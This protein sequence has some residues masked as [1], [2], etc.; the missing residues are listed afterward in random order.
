MKILQ[1]CKKFPYPLKDGETIAVTYLSKALYELGCEITLLCMNTSKHHTDVANI[2]DNYNHYKD[3]HFVDIDNSIT[4]FGAFTNLFRKESYHVSRFIS[5]EFKT[6]IIDILSKEE[7]DVIQLETLYLAPYVDLIREHTNA[8]ITMRAHNVEHEI[9]ERITK[10]TTFFPKKIYLNYL[11]KKLKKFE[12]DNLNAYDYL[13]AVTKKDLKTFKEL[14]YKNGA[15]ASPIGIET[16][17]YKIKPTA[18]RENE[19]SL[20]FIGSLDWRPNTEGLDWFLQEVWPSM[21]VKFPNLK[22]HIAGRNT[23]YSI[24]SLNLPNVIIH[25]EVESAIGFLGEHTALVVPL[26]SGSGMRVKILEG[27]A[28]GNVVI[29][30][31]LGLEGIDAKHGEEVLIADTTDAFINCVEQ[32]INDEKLVERIS[33]NAIEFVANT[34]DNIDNAKELLDTYKELMIKYA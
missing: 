18:A 5:D 30:T 20:C 32:C 19:F 13:I 31:R 14:G 28:L 7:F 8:I 29:T 27:M 17:S 1:L 6:A 23:P 4:P 22:L 10:N 16:K 24:M 2:P 33:E 15:I 26:F 3:I 11:T 9:W 21:H 12:L 34:Y 25:G